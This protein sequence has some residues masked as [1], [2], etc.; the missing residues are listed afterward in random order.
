LIESGMLLLPH[1]S[2]RSGALARGSGRTAG[3]PRRCHPAGGKGT[4]D[5]LDTSDAPTTLGTVTDA[6]SP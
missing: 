4:L 3:A 5:L 6:K 2:R 1:E